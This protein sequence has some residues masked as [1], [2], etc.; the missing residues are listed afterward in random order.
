MY[1]K[2]DPRPAAAGE[3]RGVGKGTPLY[4]GRALL[5]FKEFPQTASA[6]G[7]LCRRGE[8]R[9]PRLPVSL[10]TA[11]GGRRQAGQGSSRLREAPRPWVVGNLEPCAQPRCADCLPPL[12]RA[13]GGPAF[14][15]GPLL[16]P[17]P[18]GRRVAD[19]A[20]GVG[21]RETDGGKM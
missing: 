2:R 10:A 15:D 21:P 14:L 18:A 11:C 17:A 1:L 19:A 7:T 8:R 16:G 20:G 4:T 12:P 6:L 3:G 5:V 13:L 9:G